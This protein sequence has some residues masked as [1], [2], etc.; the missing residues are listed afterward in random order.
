MAK[1]TVPEA[2][3]ALNRFKME[4]ASVVGVQSHLERPKNPHFMRFS[5]LAKMR[6][7]WRYNTSNNQFQPKITQK[8]HKNCC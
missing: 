8:I 3:D 1:N 5:G 6:C 2:K 4:A 7:C